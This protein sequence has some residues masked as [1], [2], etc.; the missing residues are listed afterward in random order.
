MRPKLSLGRT[1]FASSLF[2]LLF[3]RIASIRDATMV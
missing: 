1:Y 2:L 3:E